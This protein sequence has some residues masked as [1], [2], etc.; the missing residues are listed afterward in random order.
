MDD[1]RAP[2]FR[3]RG[4][5]V[6]TTDTDQR[7]PGVFVHES[8]YI[9][10]GVTI[11]AG[12][13]IW[14]F[15]HVLSQTTIGRNVIIGQNVM[16]GPNVSIGDGCKIQNNVALYSGVELEADVFCGP[17]CVFTN[18][19][20]PRAAISRKNE[21][22]KTIVH[23][24]AT[25]G[26]NATILC[27]ITIGAYAFIGAGAVITRDVPAYALMVG[28]PARRTGWMSQTGDKLGPDLICPR[29]R[30]RYRENGPDQ[31]DLIQ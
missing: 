4:N 7:F 10:D 14:H 22:R 31:L 25:I 17:S 29:T 26:A 15:V 13:K 19:I 21:F 9:D 20:N 1:R 8:A 24:G 30:T 16:A 2:S 5:D 6:N 11:G 27:G 12:T 18:V 3:T 28:V 23:R